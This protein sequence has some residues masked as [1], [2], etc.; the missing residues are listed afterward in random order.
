M[1]SRNEAFLAGFVLTGQ[2][3]FWDDRFCKYSP[4]SQLSYNGSC[5]VRMFNGNWDAKKYDSGAISGVCDGI[6]LESTIGLLQNNIPAGISLTSG[7]GAYW[8]SQNQV[9]TLISSPCTSRKIFYR[10]LPDGVVF[11]S[12]LR[13][14]ITDDDRVDP[15]GASQ[16]VA[17]G[18]TGASRSI[19]S[20][21]NMIG[22]GM[23]GKFSFTNNSLSHEL[24]PVLRYEFEHAMST[25]DDE[26]GFIEN[27]H[28]GLQQTLASISKHKIAVMLSGGADSGIIACMLKEMGVRDVQLFTCGFTEDHI[29]VQYARKLAK[30]LGYPHHLKMFRY[31]DALEILNECPLGYSVPFGDYS[32]LLC[33]FLVKQAVSEVGQETYLLD[34]NGGD[35]FFGLITLAKMPRNN[36]LWKLPSL[37]KHIS[38]FCYENLG[39]WQHDKSLFRTMGLVGSSFTAH[40]LLVGLLATRWVG[41]LNVTPDQALARDQEL[42]D[43]AGKILANSNFSY[44]TLLTSLQFINICGGQW[45]AKVSDPARYFGYAVELPFMWPIMANV[46][47]DFPFAL[48]LYQGLI[49]YPLKKLLMRYV[50]ED[51]AIRPKTGP[52]PPLRGWLQQQRFN[53]WFL[54]AIA[55]RRLLGD[56]LCKIPV[57][58][59]VKAA[60]KNSHY[61]P[62]S[63]Y[64]LIW[65]VAFAEKW[66]ADARHSFTN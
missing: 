48:K 33:Y 53:Q 54:K 34:G 16:L 23:A 38:R 17:Y 5:R 21:I 61:L 59:M 7:L 15:V 57:D 51:Y 10:K 9:L 8:D 63:C 26:N 64:H 3:H 39:L 36:R 46:G 28:K 47:F 13:L 2:D 65:T 32:S 6:P 1:I 62:A 55:D 45:A 20:D 43:Y 49:K 60:L 56:I 37:I 58:E 35:D 50:P 11:S 52:T 24:V 19:F 31:E 14:L 18:S 25:V 40:P 44:E 12:D 27:I 4:F 30:Q 22:L 66:F 42:L 29:D 41:A